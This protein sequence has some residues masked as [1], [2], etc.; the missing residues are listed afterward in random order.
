MRD[1]NKQILKEKIRTNPDRTQLGEKTKTEGQTKHVRITNR[2][3]LSYGFH[4]FAGIHVVLVVF[5]VGFH[6]LQR[7]SQDLSNNK[8]KFRNRLTPGCCVI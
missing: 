4:L 2:E 5:P 3:V 7:F 8:K 1:E 6:S